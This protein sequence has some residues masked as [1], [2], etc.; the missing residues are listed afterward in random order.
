MTMD[1]RAIL[2]DQLAALKPQLFLTFQFNNFF[3]AISGRRLL[4]QFDRRASDILYGRRFYKPHNDYKR[5]IAYYF[6]EV[7]A[8]SGKS[9]W[10]SLVLFTYQPNEMI[11]K[12]MD[13]APAIWRQKCCPGGT[14]KI[15][16]LDNEESII[17][18]SIYSTKD[19]TK[20]HNNDNWILNYEFRNTK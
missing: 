8:L 6:R 11:A 7:G 5:F 1:E 18:A 14:L 12:F 16:A 15:M 3:S 17:K 20:D 19:L 4:K 10:H 9:N 13:S 2:V